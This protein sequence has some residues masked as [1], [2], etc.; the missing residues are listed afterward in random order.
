MQ[1]VQIA[2][3]KSQPVMQQLVLPMQ[4]IFTVQG[5]N[6]GAFHETVNV[7]DFP[8]NKAEDLSPIPVATPLEG[9]YATFTLPIRGSF[10]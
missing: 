4:S 7:I 8:E 3:T 6:N 2:V 9:G 1:S 10:V 5:G